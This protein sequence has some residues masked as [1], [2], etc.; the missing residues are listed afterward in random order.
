MAT[1]QPVR[2]VLDASLLLDPSCTREAAV[3]ALRPGVEELLRR[4]RYSNLT[5][6]ICYAEGMPT[7]EVLYLSTLLLHPSE[8]ASS[9]VHIDNICFLLPY[10]PIM[11]H[12]VSILSCRLQR[13]ASSNECSIEVPGVLIVQRLQ[14]LLLTLATLIKRRCGSV[15][16]A[17]YGDEDKPAL[18]TYPDVALN[19]MSCFQGFFF[20]PEV[21]S[22]LLHNF[23]VY[24]INPQGHEM[25]AAPM[26]SDVLVPSVADLANQVAD[27]LDFFGLVVDLQAATDLMLWHK[28]ASVSG[29][30]TLGL[31]TYGAHMFRPKNPAY[32][33]FGGLLTAGIVLFSG[34]CYTVAYLED[35]KFS[36]PAPLGG[37]AFI[38]AWASLLF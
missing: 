18:I 5:M 4:L 3:V 20:C 29:V 37:F 12:G 17:V 26:S 15:T 1:R 38:A 30:A 23:C 9:E 28:V 35:M 22:L 19:Y 25:G 13:M 21:A 32:K 31:G 11:A 36:S 27:V 33:E 6:A 2:L 34:T 8:V 16:I 24:H 7:N 10:L 14:Q